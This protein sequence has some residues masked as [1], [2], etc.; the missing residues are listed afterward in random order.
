MTRDDEVVIYLNRHADEFFCAACIAKAVEIN[1][2]Q[3]SN[4][5]RPLRKTSDFISREKELCSQC[6]K[7]RKVIKATALQ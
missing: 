3:A 1:P 5:V 2:T 4:A 6:L 7:Y